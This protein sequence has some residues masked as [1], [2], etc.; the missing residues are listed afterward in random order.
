[1]KQ[2]A[3]ILRAAVGGTTELDRLTTA[4][5][6]TDA[7]KQS[8]ALLTLLVRLRKAAGLPP[9]V[10]KD[11]GP[12]ELLELIERL[13]AETLKETTDGEYAYEMEDETDCPAPAEQGATRWDGE[14]P[15]P[16]G[17]RVDSDEG[18]AGG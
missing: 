1:M 16:S 10:V 17:P 3:E 6:G 14:Q 4:L 11:E 13:E 8:G 7:A 2:V 18:G 12:K 15:A 9:L 5:A